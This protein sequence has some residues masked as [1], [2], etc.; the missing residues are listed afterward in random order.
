[1]QAFA[2]LR[3]ILKEELGLDPSPEMRRLQQRILLGLEPRPDDEGHDR[4]RTA[5]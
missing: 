5:G 4:A 2:S 1:M 3:K